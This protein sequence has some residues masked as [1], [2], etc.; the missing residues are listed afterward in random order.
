M[1]L[2]L[3]RMKSKSKES[4]FELFKLAAAKGEGMEG[5]KK[6]KKKKKKKR[7]WAGRVWPSPEHL[8]KHLK[9]KKKKKK[10]RDYI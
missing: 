3:T 10:R 1:G 7:G 8:I 9:V 5:V 2:I 6:K 4:A